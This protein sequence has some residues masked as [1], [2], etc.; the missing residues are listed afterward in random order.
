MFLWGIGEGRWETGNGIVMIVIKTILFLNLI[1][2]LEKILMKNLQRN[3]YVDMYSIYVGFKHRVMD[4]K[5]KYT[6]T[7]KLVNK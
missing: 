1:N 4:C 7:E 5:H 2:N 6:L 3:C